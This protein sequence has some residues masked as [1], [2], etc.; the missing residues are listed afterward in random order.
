M[1]PGSNW[2][3]SPLDDTSLHLEELPILAILTL[4]NNKGYKKAGALTQKDP[5]VM[6]GKLYVTEAEP[7]VVMKGLN[8]M[9]AF[10]KGMAAPQLTFLALY[11]TAVT[12]AC[13]HCALPYKAD[14]QLTVFVKVVIRKNSTTI[15]GVPPKHLEEIPLLAVL[16][17]L[18]LASLPMD[19]VPATRA[20]KS[21]SI[22]GR[23]SSR[24][25]QLPP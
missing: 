9:G 3:S 19:P 24:A 10:V 15:P 22:P 16:G 1:A 2:P 12:K 11:S 4:A 21:P 7:I 13:T 6:L 20:T 14:P 8:M 17:P 5:P 18:H 25:S 23:N